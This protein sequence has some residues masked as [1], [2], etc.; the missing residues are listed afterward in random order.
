M[1]STRRVVRT[2]VAGLTLLGGSLGAAACSGGTDKARSARSGATTPTTVPALPTVPTTD[3]VVPEPLADQTPPK[4]ANGLAFDAA[5]ILW[6]A[7]LAGGQILA[8]D[9]GDGSI[10][11][12]LAAAQGVA[13]PDDLAF[14]ADGTLWWT[15]YEGGHLGRIDRPAQPGA[16]SVSVADVGPGA[17][18]V[19]VADD[20]TVFVGRTIL[21]RGLWALTPGATTLRQVAGDP[22]LINA[23][24]FGPDARLYAPVGDAGTV[25][26]IDPV[27]GTVE[28]VA[29]G[30][31]LPVS[32]R[33]A[34]D[35]RLLVL[36]A[37]PAVVSEVNPRTGGVSVIQSARSDVADN[38]A[39]GPDGR[40]YITAFDQPAISVVPTSGG[41]ASVLLVGA[42]PR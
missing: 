24:A 40:L 27:D 23:F 4:G 42:R 3:G 37:A 25:V 10:L 12:R 16:A 28:K 31:S 18:P 35:G 41:E 5:G 29:S 11:V 36:G 13:S 6:L 2:A 38:M 34:P 15:D 19:A 1:G 8:V 26:A 7:D 22:G 9:P 20:G 32:V 33:W 14:D 17:N 30:L 39:F 21:G